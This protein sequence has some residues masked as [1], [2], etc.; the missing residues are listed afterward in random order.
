[1]NIIEDT[2]TRRRRHLRIPSSSRLTR[3]GSTR[4][5]MHGKTATTLPVN[6]HETTNRFGLRT[7]GSAA[8]TN[9]GLSTTHYKPRKSSLPSS[10]GY[11][12]FRTGVSATPSNH[13][14][15]PAS[16]SQS[17]TLITIPHSPDDDSMRSDSTESGRTKS[18]TVRTAMTQNTVNMHKLHQ[19]ENEVM[20]K[21][22]QTFK[23]RVSAILSSR[24]SLP[25]LQR[26]PTAKAV[27][28]EMINNTV[29]RPTSNILLGSKRWLSPREIRL[30]ESSNAPKSAKNHSELENTL[31]NKQKVDGE[32]TGMDSKARG[33]LK[34]GA[35][36]K[37]IPVVQVASR[38]KKSSPEKQSRE[39]DPS[40]LTGANSLPRLGLQSEQQKGT[41]PQD[42]IDRAIRESKENFDLILARMPLVSDARMRRTLEDVL[43]P[44]AAAIEAT[45]VA[46]NAGIRLDGA[47]ADLTILTAQMGAKAG[48]L[49]VHLR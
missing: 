41:L 44:L 33:P 24:R 14:G 49:A 31:T 25:S 10:P 27:K 20:K 36:R 9:I 4:K 39:T 11:I 46:R 3:S 5:S 21:P 7:A 22:K 43:I 12:P 35:D 47:I 17:V 34:L 30:S 23:N 1:M 15:V 13:V 18:D 45:I 48:Q 8:Q 29:L 19:P 28:V 40:E 42:E 16:A 32:N 26:A 37:G 6:A 38:N 2:P